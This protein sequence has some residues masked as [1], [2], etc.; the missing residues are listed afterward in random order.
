MCVYVVCG[1]CVCA[2]V[3]VY[4]LVCVRVGV[5]LALGCL[6][7]ATPGCDG[8]LG[9]VFQAYMFF[10]NLM[11]NMVVSSYAEKNARSLS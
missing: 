11:E 1:C 7:S 2:Y 3:S 5:C 9:D 4:M 6:W 8:A 10:N